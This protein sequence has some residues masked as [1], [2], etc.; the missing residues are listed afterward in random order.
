MLLNKDSALMSDIREIQN[1]YKDRKVCDFAVM[2]S[3]KLY[4]RYFFFSQK[5][6]KLIK[7]MQA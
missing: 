4:L 6:E 2:K 5:R 3:K 7:V 1:F